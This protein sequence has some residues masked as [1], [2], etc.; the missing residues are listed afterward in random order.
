MPRKNRVLPTGTTLSVQELSHQYFA[1]E[2]QP[3]TV[4]LSFKVMLLSSLDLIDGNVT[5]HVY[6]YA[7]WLEPALCGV[8]RDDPRYPKTPDDWE[9]M[10]HPQLDIN[11]SLD[12]E[13][14][15]CQD[16]GWDRGWLSSLDAPS[17]LVSFVYDLRGRISC[18]ADQSTFP[19]DVVR[20]RNLLMTTHSAQ[21]TKSNYYFLTRVLDF[22]V[23][24]IINVGPQIWKNHRVILAPSTLLGPKHNT[25]I[26]SVLPE[27]QPF[28]APQLA[29]LDSQTNYSN[30]N[31]TITYERQYN[32]YMWKVVLI[33]FIIAAISWFIPFMDV[34]AF[35]DRLN[36]LLTLLLASVAF[37]YVV[38]D[39]L[40]AVSYLT[41]LDK[42][43]LSAFL[44]IFVSAL[45]TFAVHLLAAPDL[46]ANESGARALDWWARRCLP[47][48]SISST[49]FFITKGACVVA[50]RRRN[51]CRV[52]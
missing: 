2:A 4:W 50:Q 18:D 35:A 43:T 28:G 30:A 33:Q 23:D 15:P 1:N 27:W 6:M 19:F 9:G 41:I 26:K 42:I 39:K 47:L 29:V 20:D 10:W 16:R 37:L 11:N 5:V 52:V 14:I 40:P 8:S 45:E 12:L 7:T 46:G 38:N 31:F 44:F 13:V 24:I 22:Q 34:F 48:A 51:R 17:D 3:R 32:Y 21:T 25:V 49:L 36:A